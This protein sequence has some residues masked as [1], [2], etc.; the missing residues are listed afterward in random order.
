MA[1]RT[2]RAASSKNLGSDLGLRIDPHSNLPVY[3]QIRQQLTWLIASSRLVPGARLPTVRELARR[4][5]INLHTVRQAYLALEADGLLETKPGRGTTVLAA[6]PASFVGGAAASHTV[7]VLLPNMTPLYADFLKALEEQASALGYMPITCFTHDRADDTRRLA[8]QLAS[9]R[10]QG[11]IAVAPL[12]GVL[13]PEDLPG[14]PI[15]YADAPGRT[16]N[17][18]VLNIEQAGFKAA[19]HLIEHGHKRIGLITA[20]LLDGSNRQA[21]RGFERALREARLQMHPE[22]IVEVPAYLKEFGGQA[23]RS[24]IEMKRR[25]SAVFAS[26]DVLAV[27]AVEALREGGWRIP[28]DMAIASKD[29]SEFAGLI[30]PPLTTVSLP[31]YE[32]GAESMRQ[33]HALITGGGSLRKKTLAGERLVVRRSCGCTGPAQ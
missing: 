9:L 2:S 18:V 3:A 14:L 28:E 15:V 22:W 5:H 29:N 26:G 27:G 20:P 33:L 7:G 32:L 1:T 19:R 8:Q 17:S 21:A 25:P 24:L 30:N 13:E 11:V 23:M 31:V 12:A 10:V 16:R 4:L 6:P